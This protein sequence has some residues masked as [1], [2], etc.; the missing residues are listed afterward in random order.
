MLV[1][2]EERKIEKEYMNSMYWIHT[3]ILIYSKEEIIII[4]MK[5]KI[6]I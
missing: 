3:S 4:I 1:P 5:K 2:I 6:N